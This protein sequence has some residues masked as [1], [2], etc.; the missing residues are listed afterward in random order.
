[1][2][3]ITEEQALDAWAYIKSYYRFRGRDIN[4]EDWDAFPMDWWTDDVKKAWETYSAFFDQIPE[5]ADL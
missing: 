5:G 2:K 4:E 3:E 1:M